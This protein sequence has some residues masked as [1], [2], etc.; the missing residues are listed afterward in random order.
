MLSSETTLNPPNM[1][2]KKLLMGTYVA[3]LDIGQ[4]WTLRKVLP[5]RQDVGKRKQM[6]AADAAWKNKTA[7]ADVAKDRQ[8]MA[9]MRSLTSLRRPT[10]SN[11]NRTQS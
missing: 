2:W 11:T 7:Q 10:L 5:A 3:A 1:R 8:L 6:E 4:F 9:L